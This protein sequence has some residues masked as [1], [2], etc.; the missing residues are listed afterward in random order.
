MNVKKKTKKKT[1]GQMDKVEGEDGE[2]W[3]RTVWG[4]GVSL[5]RVVRW[6]VKEVDDINLRNKNC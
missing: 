5:M 4:P 3:W 2:G 1:E 6:D